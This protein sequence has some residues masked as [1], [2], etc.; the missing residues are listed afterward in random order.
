M[1]PSTHNIIPDGEIYCVWMDAGLVDYK[2]CD[3][4]YDCEQCPFDNVIRTRRGQSANAGVSSL[5]RSEKQSPVR[6]ESSESIDAILRQALAKNFNHIMETRLPEHRYYFANHTWLSPIN[7]QSCTIGVDHL[8][9]YVLSPIRSIA[10]PR[11][12]THIEQNNPCAWL[13]RGNETLAV[14]SPIA[15]TI[16]EINPMLN[17]NAVTLNDD[18]YNNGWL[19]KVT[20][21]LPVESLSPKDSIQFR[22]TFDADAEK[23]QQLFIAEFQRLSSRMGTTMYDGGAVIDSIERMIGTKRFTEIIGTLITGNKKQ[24]FR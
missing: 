23:L 14:R 1:S 11:P 9:A 24:K 6:V 19:I 17:D 4:N 8:L 22:S 15:G 20:P 12:N 16:I 10:T 7:E 18:P 13:M 5:H 2:L 3:R 21:N